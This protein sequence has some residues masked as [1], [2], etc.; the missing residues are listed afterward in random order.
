MFICV[1]VC[2]ISVRTTLSEERKGNFCPIVYFYCTKVTFLQNLSPEN[3]PR[4]A[5]KLN[6]RPKLNNS[7]FLLKQTGHLL[8]TFKVKFSHSE[9]V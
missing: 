1:C 2:F 3:Y 8:V 5:L 6:L 9:Y 4:P 7:T